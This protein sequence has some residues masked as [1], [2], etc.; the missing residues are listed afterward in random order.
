MAEHLLRL[1]SP[2]THTHARYVNPEELVEF[3][4]KDVPW[5]V[6]PSP[7][8]GAGVEDR[9]PER[10][11]V[12]TRG[13]A[14]LPWKGAWELAPRWAKGWGSEQANYFFWIRRPLNS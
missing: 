5:L 7:A 11:R 13:V 1:V 8:G 4:K 14:Y 9:T 2:G 12:E 6:S 3:F 10:L